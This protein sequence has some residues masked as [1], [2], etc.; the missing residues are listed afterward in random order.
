MMVGVTPNVETDSVQPE[1]SPMATDMTDVGKVTVYAVIADPSW[2][3]ILPTCSVAAS[4]DTVF[5]CH[6]PTETRCPRIVEVP[7][8][9]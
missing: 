4:M 8:E 9:Q 2:I 1:L 6:I 5:A 7:F 3:K